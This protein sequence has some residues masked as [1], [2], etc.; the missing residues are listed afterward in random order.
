MKKNILAALALLIIIIGLG[1]YFGTSGNK[2]TKTTTVS[3]TTNNTISDSLKTSFT[4]LVK[5]KYPDWEIVNIASDPMCDGKEAYD[6]AL[7]KTTGD[8]KSIIVD[9]NAILIQT[10]VDAQINTLPPNITNLLKSNYSKYTYGDSYEDLTVANGDKQYLIDITQ[11]GG[12]TTA[13]LILNQSGNI[14]CETKAK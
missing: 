5:Q 7:K 12:K 11:D 3:Q 2:T 14:V 13:E 1:F 6:I 4:S 10:E 8:K 9:K